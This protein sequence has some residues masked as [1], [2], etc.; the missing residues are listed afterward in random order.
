MKNNDEKEYCAFCLRDQKQVI[1]LIRGK[2]A[3]I[4]DSCLKL[5]MSVINEG[6]KKL[7]PERVAEEITENKILRPK[8]LKK[9]LDDYVIDQDEAKKLIS[10][11]VYNHYKRIKHNEK[12]EVEISK[13]NILILGST[14]CGKTLLAQTVAKVLD[15]PFIIADATS[16]TESGYV[17]GDA[18]DVITKLLAAAGGNIEK[19]EHGIV[20]IDE[21][22]KL[23]KKDPTGSRTR[24]VGGEGVQQAL[25]KMIEGTEVSVKAEEGTRSPFRVSFNTKEVL[26][27]L[28]GAFNGIEEVIEKRTGKAN[29]IGFGAE[30]KNQKEIKDAV[31]ITDVKPDDLIN[32]GLIPEFIGRIQV[33]APLHTLDEKALLKILSEP[34]D[35]LV[36]QFKAL[37]SYDDVDLHFTAGALKAIAK[38]AI[39]RKTGARGLRSIIEETMINVMYELPEEEFI[40]KCVISQ[41]VIEENTPPVLSYFPHPEEATQ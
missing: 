14:G 41:R 17:G 25:L 18:E 22:D 29:S 9:L 3:S 24:D 10:V 21:I 4:C 15:V 23:A 19:A 26:F 8:Q 11:A 34:K 7:E 37:L 39:K 40:N 31:S 33:I 1:K 2:E 6:E 20:Y 35:A 28:G 13:S 5:G 12:E 27:I 32:F 36:K 16:I 30:V 38:K